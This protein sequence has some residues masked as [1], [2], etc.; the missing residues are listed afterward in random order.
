[1]QVGRG[2]GFA[3]V[4]AKTSTAVLV[5]LPC[6]LPGAL[7]RQDEQVSDITRPSS[8][9]DHYIGDWD[10]WVLGNGL[11]ELPSAVDVDESVPVAY[12]RLGGWAAVLNLT[13]VEADPEVGEPA[14]LDTDTQSFRWTGREW[15][16]ADGS[17][18][19]NWFPGLE[20]RR[21]SGLGPQDVVAIHQGSFAT[22]TWTS[23]VLDGVAGVEAEAIEVD[24]AGRRH[25]QPLDSPVGAWVAAFD[26][27]QSAT[28]RVL[29]RGAVLF[30]SHVAPIG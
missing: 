13:Y 9:D 20:V 5:W 24:Q 17:G 8:F 11:P 28:V 23:A 30:E 18:G 2:R 1:M 21:P 10:V 6:W 4:R 15:E 12:W 25:R 3:G 16:M 26:G 29:G 19:T 7:V 14:S 27:R 22:P